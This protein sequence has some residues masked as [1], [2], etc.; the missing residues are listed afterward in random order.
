MPFL[1]LFLLLFSFFTSPVRAAGEFGLSQTITYQFD[2][3]GNAQVFQ[4]ITL[5]NKL[6]NIHAT[7]YQI[8]ISS[9]AVQNIKAIEGD[10]NLRT[11]IKEPQRNLTQVTVFFDQPVAGLGKKRQF[12]LQYF[13]PDYAKKEGQTWRVLIPKINEMEELEEL[14]I[15]INVPKNWGPASFVSPK[16]YTQEEEGER[17]IVT[18]SKSQLGEKEVMLI[19][20]QTQTFRFSLNYYLE[21]TSAEEKIQALALPPD[22]S[23]Q[24]IFLT[25]I[26]PEP[27]D[28]EA[29]D[30]GNW[31]AS[32][33]LPPN[34][35]IRVKA[36]GLAQISGQP[37]SPPLPPK[38][39]S[40]YL[41]A[42]KY[43]EKDAP[44][45]QDLAEKL[46]TPEEIY[47][48][49]LATLDYNLEKV[50]NRQVQRQGALNAFNNPDQAI[51]TEFT[52]LFIALARAAGIPS[53]ELN[54]YAYS[55]N[56]ELLPLTLDADV[57]HAW[58]E[59]WDE[60]RQT[61]IQVD[62]TWEDTSGID[63]FNKLDMSHLVFVIHGL[64]SVSPPPAGAY[65][66]PALGK[67]K[68]V[69]VEFSLAPQAELLPLAID[70]NLPQK[71]SFGQKANGAITVRNVNPVAFYNQ[72]V[73]ITSEGLPLEP[74]GKTLTAFPPYANEVFAV[75]FTNQNLFKESV[76]RILVQ[77]GN[78]EPVAATIILTSPLANP[79]FLNLLIG[80]AGIV[81]VG[82]IIYLVKSFK[83][84]R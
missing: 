24:K 43:W 5:E 72:E 11:E 20:G 74:F 18:F 70:F 12:N 28:V 15:N 69:E 35:A 41:Q 48:F 61:W 42:K 14:T 9:G 46:K 49:V 81:V 50:K 38:D 66:D 23:Y 47:Q 76:G 80:L 78:Q 10:Q 22:T 79:L 84:R 1:F 37:L 40:Q 45:F 71:V 29:D 25:K 73:K 39:L 57:L 4:E 6:A 51:C 59:Y 8:T 33:R 58:P 32:Y 75:N 44:P 16:N 30:D 26:D 31:L 55:T 19:F 54:G 53:R 64:D 62:P 77:V 63:Y 36:E 13:L 83:K 17:Q 27:L 2:Q 67:Q 21:N 60:K 7:Q 68:N 82:I 3:N 52:D 65:Q 34:S 56:P